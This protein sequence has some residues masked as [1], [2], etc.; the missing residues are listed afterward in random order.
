MDVVDSENQVTFDELLFLFNAAMR[1]YSQLRDAFQADFIRYE[2]G[3][4]DLAAASATANTAMD[5]TRQPED[6]IPPQFAQYAKTRTA[7]TA[8]DLKDLARKFN[9]SNKSMQAVFKEQNI[10]LPVFPEM[11]KSAEESPPLSWILWAFEPDSALLATVSETQY[12][13][14]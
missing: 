9:V 6:K 5:I 8:N 11:M 1:D 4:L 14:T 12:Q 13:L 10:Y 7:L 2:S 3:T